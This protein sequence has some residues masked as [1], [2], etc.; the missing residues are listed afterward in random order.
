MRAVRSSPELSGAL[1]GSVTESG[2][3]HELATRAL[4]G[5]SGASRRFLE[6]SRPLW[7]SPELSGAIQSPA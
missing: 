1:Q 4:R 2:N 5:F 3:H 6:L 7:S